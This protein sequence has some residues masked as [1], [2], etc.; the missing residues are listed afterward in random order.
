MIKILIFLYSISILG[1][2]LRAKVNE[3]ELA[4]R[5]DLWPLNIKTTETI[6]DDAGFPILKA[7]TSGILLRIEEEKVILDTGRLGIVR[8][9]ISKTNALEIAREIES[10]EVAKSNGNIVSMLG[11][12]FF[13]P[14]GE[15]YQPLPYF[16]F[17]SVDYF[18][19]YYARGRDDDCIR[20]TEKL[21]S[22]YK[23]IK[24][25]LPHFELLMI[26]LD[27]DNEAMFKHLEEQQ[28]PWPTMFHYMARGYQKAL[29]H[30]PKNLPCL[31]LTDANGKIL[32]HSIKDYERN[33]PESVLQIIKEKAFE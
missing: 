29:D 25:K 27:D 15:G 33:N 32:A 14:Q 7:A 20:F 6:T 17:K 3:E 24:D 21:R 13:D 18:L 4:S 12:K 23:T 10:G 26:P 8:I 9:P 22:E 11:G 5:S 31:V 28:I 2:I 16:E 30:K 1:S 19:F